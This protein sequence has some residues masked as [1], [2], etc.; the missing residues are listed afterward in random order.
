MKTFSPHSNPPPSVFID[1]NTLQQL[2]K[3]NITKHDAQK[4]AS[5]AERVFESSETGISSVSPMGNSSSLTQDQRTSSMDGGHVSTPVH[6]LT[7]SHSSMTNSS[8]SKQPLPLRFEKK[9]TKEEDGSITYAV[10]LSRQSGVFALKQISRQHRRSAF[11]RYEEVKL[12]QSLLPHPNLAD[13][14]CAFVKGGRQFTLTEHTP[15]GVRTHFSNS[16]S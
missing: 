8:N 9:P 15:F 5:Q 10:R 2:I 7:F 1:S 4:L 13:F 3:I 6:I 14:E 11:L 12:L 16:I